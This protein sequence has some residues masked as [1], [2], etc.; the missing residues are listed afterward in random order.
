M[1]CTC[2]GLGGNLIVLI[3]ITNSLRLKNSIEEKLY[4]LEVVAAKN[5]TIKININEDQY[6]VFKQH[7]DHLRMLEQFNNSE[8]I[9]YNTLLVDFLTLRIEDYFNKK[10]SIH[11]EKDL[12]DEWLM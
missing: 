2:L 10:Y 9:N 8:D 11:C 5:F 6:E 1:L 7:V 12:I 3:I 4:D